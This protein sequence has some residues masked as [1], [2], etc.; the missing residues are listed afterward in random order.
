MTCSAHD[1]DD[2]DET[3]DNDSQIPFLR[4]QE[5][6]HSSTMKQAFCSMQ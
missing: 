1:D 2:D 4:S 6:C 5:W 3:N